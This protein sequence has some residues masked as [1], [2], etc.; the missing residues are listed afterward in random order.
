MCYIPAC[1]LERK[2][3]VVNAILNITQRKN[4]AAVITVRLRSSMVRRR[5]HVGFL[6]KDITKC[7]FCTKL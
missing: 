5:H 1:C 3:T 4:A 2:T 7:K 6:K